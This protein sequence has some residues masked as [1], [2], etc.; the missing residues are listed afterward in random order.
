MKK[1]VIGFFVGLFFLTILFVCVT[2]AMSSIHGVNF[3]QEIQ[4][5]F[6][7]KP[8]T[9]PVD[10]GVQAMINLLKL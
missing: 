3:V 4:S 9:P 10:E 8:V 6:N 2:L 7:V 5:W 1:G